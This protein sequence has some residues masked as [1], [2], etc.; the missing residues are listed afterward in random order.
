[1]ADDWRPIR[2][3][4]QD[5]T[6]IEVTR[7]GANLCRVAWKI[8][9]LPECRANGVLIPAATLRGWYKADDRLYAPSPTDWRPVAAAEPVVGEP[10]AWAP[11]QTVAAV[12]GLYTVTREGHAGR[13]SIF[14]CGILRDTA[15]TLDAAAAFVLSDDEEDDLA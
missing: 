13:F 8:Y 6:I 1:M 3:A 9:P 14:Y 12:Y 4:P 11:G 7:H 5:G 15:D 10:C 2:T